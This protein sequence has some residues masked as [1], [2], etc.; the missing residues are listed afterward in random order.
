MTLRKIADAPPEPCL[1]P[2]HHPPTMIVLQPGTY[3]H[4]CVGCGRRAVIH[5]PRV[6]S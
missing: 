3:E 6:I 2:G 1:H 4:T 5:V